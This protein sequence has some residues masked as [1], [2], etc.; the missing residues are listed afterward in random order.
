MCTLID[1][2]AGQYFMRGVLVAVSL[3][4]RLVAVSRLLVGREGNKFLTKS[5]GG[6]NRSVQHL[7]GVYLPEFQI[8][9]FF[10]DVD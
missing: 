5:R 6:L 8:P 9:K 10:L 3:K 4:D 7:P 1:V 2:A